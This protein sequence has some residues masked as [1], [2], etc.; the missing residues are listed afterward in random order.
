M[1]ISRYQIISLALQ[2]CACSFIGLID[3][4]VAPGDLSQGLVARKKLDETGV[5]TLKVLDLSTGTHHRQTNC[6]L[7]N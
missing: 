2:M 1:L 3:D 7:S 5:D 4:S 6:S